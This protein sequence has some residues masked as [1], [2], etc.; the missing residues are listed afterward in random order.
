MLYTFKKGTLIF[1][2]AEKGTLSPD[3][4]EGVSYTP[5]EYYTT[6]LMVDYLGICT[7]LRAYLYPSSSKRRL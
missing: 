5:R 3:S 6:V 7:L 2:Y 4:D 1:L